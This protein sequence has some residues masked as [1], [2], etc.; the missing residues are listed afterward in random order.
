[1]YGHRWRIAR[2][3]HL[4][5]HPLCVYCAAQG[6]RTPASVVD[7]VTPHRGD[8]ALFWAA[9][10]WQ[11]LCKTCHDGAKQTLEKSGY[12]KGS[13]LEGLPLDVR[14]PWHRGTDE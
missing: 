9:S 6:Y 13:T 7:H 5:L 2:A 8:S 3:R 14:H 11:S 1:M 10:N 4:A 12:L